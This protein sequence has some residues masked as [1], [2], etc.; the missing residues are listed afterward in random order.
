[1]ATYQHSL[2]GY[3]DATRRR[4]LRGLGPLQRWVQDRIRHAAFGLRRGPAKA[5]GLDDRALAD[6]GL[7]RSAVTTPSELPFEVGAS[8]A[9]HNVPAEHRAAT[10]ALLGR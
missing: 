1:M 6:I 8:P 4:S 2:P 9:L 5:A 7:K 3:S 10:F